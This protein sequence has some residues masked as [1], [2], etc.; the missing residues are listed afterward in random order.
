[1]EGKT[2]NIKNKTDRIEQKKQ[3]KINTTK[4]VKKMV[5]SIKSKIRIAD[6][7]PIV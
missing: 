4:L 1:M 3:C 6:K 2:S 7:I 5:P